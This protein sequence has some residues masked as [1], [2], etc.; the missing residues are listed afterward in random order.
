[1]GSGREEYQILDPFAR[2]LAVG[3]GDDADGRGGDGGSS[4][5]WL[6]DE[7]TTANGGGNETAAVAAVAAG[8]RILW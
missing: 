3:Q 1:M 8:G 2:V 5:R 7:I 4:R 6:A